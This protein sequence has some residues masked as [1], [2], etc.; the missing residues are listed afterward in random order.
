MPMPGPPQTI[1]LDFDNIVQQWQRMNS[2]QQTY[3]FNWFE[4]FGHMA[5]AYDA[6]VNLCSYLVA[7]GF[8][9]PILRNTERIHD[10]VDRVQL[11]PGEWREVRADEPWPEP[12]P[13]T[14][15]IGTG[16]GANGTTSA[17]LQQAAIERLRTFTTPRNVDPR[18][19]PQEGDV[20]LTGVPLPRNDSIPN[21]IPE[22]SPFGE[23]ERNNKSLIKR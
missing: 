20:I 18:G 3:T 1:L 12:P 15:Q 6:Y 7:N 16:S 5:H 21:V 17:D 13:R 10:A 4:N 22:E 14:G 23:W 19:I 8:L 11:R 9:V 2:A